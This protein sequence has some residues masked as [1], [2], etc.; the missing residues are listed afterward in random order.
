MALKQE[1][2]MGDSFWKVYKP[3]FVPLCWAFVCWD[4][5]WEIFQPSVRLP[6][7]LGDVLN[8]FMTLFFNASSHL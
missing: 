4:A 6:C 8:V 5:F 2:W 3:P 7:L 1:K